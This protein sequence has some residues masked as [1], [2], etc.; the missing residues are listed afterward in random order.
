MKLIG[1]EHFESLI[2]N[3]LQALSQFLLLFVNINVI[4]S[5]YK[6]CTQ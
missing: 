1:S 3:T 2:Y 6:R 4:H 5:L